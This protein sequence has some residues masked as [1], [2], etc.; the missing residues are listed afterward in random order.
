MTQDNATPTGTTG[1]PGLLTED[2]RAFVTLLSQA[3][4]VL[5]RI[6]DADGGGSL[7]DDVGFGHQINLL[8][9]AVL[10]QAAARAYPNDFTL[11]GASG[12]DSASDDSSCRSIGWTNHGTVHGLCAR[13][14]GHDGDHD[15]KPM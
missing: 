8:Q 1:D 14:M 10:S 12:D 7:V 2:E 5:N 4:A 9:R 11:L 6:M 15:Y 3:R 13:P